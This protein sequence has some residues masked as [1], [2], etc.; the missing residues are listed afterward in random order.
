MHKIHLLS[1]PLYSAAVPINKSVLHTQRQKASS[2]IHFCVQKGINNKGAA[3][4]TRSEDSEH[5]ALLCLCITSNS[6]EKTYSN[7]AL[8]RKEPCYKRGITLVS[9]REDSRPLRF[10]M[11]YV[12][13]D[14]YIHAQGRITDTHELLHT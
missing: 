5:S 13:R 9:C 10:C 8:L 3:L 1:T 4:V 11:K 2:H 6:Q 12:K 7:R 14:L